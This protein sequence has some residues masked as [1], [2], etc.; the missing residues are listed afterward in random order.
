MQYESWKTM[1]RNLNYFQ[2]LNIAP[3][4][5]AWFRSQWNVPLWFIAPMEYTLIV[6]SSNG[7]YPHG[8][9]PKRK[10]HDFMKW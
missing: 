3:L 4:E 5:K 6:Y 1:L 10:R 8:L 7:I 9:Y 2:C